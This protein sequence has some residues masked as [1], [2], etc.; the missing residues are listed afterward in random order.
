MD[1]DVL[2][3][4]VEYLQSTSKNETEAPFC[5]SVSFML[6]HPPYVASQVDFDAVKH[7]IPALLQPE[8]PHS[9]HP[10]IKKWREAKSLDDVTPDDIQRAR[11]AYYGLVRQLDNAI[12]TLL[13]TLDDIGA[14]DNTLVVYV[15]DHGDHLGERGLFWKHTLYEDSVKV[16]LIMSWPGKI[17]ANTVCDAPVE[18]GGLGNTILSLTDSP[19][20]PNASMIG[21][22]DKLGTTP[23]LSL[24]QTPEP[25][26][27]HP[28]FIEYC[29]DDLPSW[30]EGF[31]VQQ[32]AVIQNHHKLIYS[33]GYPEQLYDLAADPLEVNNLVDQAGFSDLVAH[34]RDL[35]LQNWDPE[36]IRQ[37]IEKRRSDK[38]LLK[39]WAERTAP[40]EYNRWPLHPDQNSLFG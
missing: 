8:P 26:D 25:P 13:T 24:P 40:A 7:S 4:S 20:L 31:A 37:T 36:A 22:A 12:G 33:H 27:T 19:T 17:P 38:A 6:P 10:W 14:T 23:E 9:E 1:A 18:T 39:A 15:S 3:A 34:L 30:S 32:R 28:I 21:F 5:L 11:T 2:S 35:V 29:T 16:P